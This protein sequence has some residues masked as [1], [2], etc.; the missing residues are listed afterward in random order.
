MQT[1]WMLEHKKYLIPPRE[2]AKMAAKVT[3]KHK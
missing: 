3:N 2:K 1:W